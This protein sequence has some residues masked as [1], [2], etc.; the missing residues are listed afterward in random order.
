VIPRLLA[1]HGKTLITVCRLAPWKGVEP[2]IRLLAQLQ[3]TRL[4][5]CGSGHL[6]THLEEVAERIGVAERVLFL[7]DVPHSSIDGYLRQADAFVLN[8][9]YEGLPHVVL[10][11]M[12]ARV[13]VVAT[14]AGGTSEVVEHNVT[15][16]LVPVGDAAALQSAVEQLWSDPALC[17]RLV[18][19]AA[20]RAQTHFDFERMVAATEQTLRVALV[21]PSRL[22]LEF[23]ETEA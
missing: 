4:V 10:E 9:T 5:I 6:R 16:L 20:A 3:Q 21:R 13:P 15:G 7:G 14:D 2:L 11:A 22:Q 18:D 17:Q 12:A 19:A 8:S 1:W 23:K